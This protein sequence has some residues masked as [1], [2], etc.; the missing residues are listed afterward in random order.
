MRIND[1]FK[2]FNIFSNSIVVLASMKM[3]ICGIIFLGSLV[4]YILIICWIIYSVLEWESSSWQQN[5]RPKTTTQRI[6]ELH[7][8]SMPSNRSFEKENDSKKV[9]CLRSLVLHG[10]LFA[11]IL[12]PYSLLENC[13]CKISN[14][15][16][17]MKV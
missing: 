8:F 5:Y 1:I 9:S 16:F 13:V 7:I 4:L 12:C 15:S 11:K 14:N 2:V 10:W 3:D 6:R 17:A